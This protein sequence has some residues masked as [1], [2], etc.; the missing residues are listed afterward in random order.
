MLACFHPVTLQRAKKGARL[1]A[2]SLCFCSMAAGEFV[3]VERVVIMDGKKVSLPSLPYPYD[4]LVAG[5]HGTVVVLIH[6]DAKG[7][8]VTCRVVHT[9]GSKSLDQSATGFILRNWK[10][11][12]VAGMTVKESIVYLPPEK[13]PPTPSPQKAKIA[14]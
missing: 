6:F 3:G 2:L 7:R 4:A 10:N 13:N 5:V 1:L 12:V 11:S 8:A 14:N 9:S